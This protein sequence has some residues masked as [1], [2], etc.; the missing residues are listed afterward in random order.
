MTSS[1]ILLLTLVAVLVIFGGDKIPEL[2]RGVGE[3]FADIRD[4]M[5]GH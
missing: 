5:N 4:A 3:G 2:L 1:E